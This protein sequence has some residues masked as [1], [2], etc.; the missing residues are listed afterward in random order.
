MSKNIEESKM[1][2]YYVRDFLLINLKEHELKSTNTIT[3][4]RQGL[5][6]FRIFTKEVHEKG[7]DKLTFEIVTADIVKDYLKWLIE[8]KG[9]SVTTR[10]HRLTVIKQYM[11]YCSDKDISL[12][13]IYIAIS[14]IKH[15]SVRA[16]KGNWMTRDA[17]KTILDQPPKTRIGIRNRFLMIFLYGTGARI[18]EALNVKLVDL[19]LNT[20]DPFVRIVGK[21]NKP[22]C[23]PL[24]DI[25][26]ENL[27]YYLS[28]YHPTN[29]AEDYLFYTVIKN[30]QDKMSTANAERF[31]KIYGKKAREICS[32]VPE[33]VYPHLFRHSYGA[34]LYRMGFPLPVI[35]KLLDHES[36]E[37]TEIYASTDFEMINSAFNE[38]EKSIKINNPLQEK[39]KL[40][41]QADE[42]T[43]AKLYGLR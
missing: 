40:W 30:K 26:I 38:M 10:N 42:E 21:G 16:K 5:N 13:P 36:L 15:I 41:K 31:I 4:Y 39:E 34:H 27:D 22:R 25:T 28:L 32:Q 33:S 17:I 11:Q 23:V 20:S 2:F 12:A 3:S 29:I 6:S 37:T 1:F 24:L 35:A 43:L 14:K 9:C 8:N 18:S 19:E 7:L